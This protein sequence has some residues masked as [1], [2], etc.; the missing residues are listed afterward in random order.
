M[1]RT[2][3]ASFRNYSNGSASTA[4]SKT[5]ID[6]MSPAGIATSEIE[7]CLILKKTAQSSNNSNNSNNSVWQLHKPDQ[8]QLNKIMTNGNA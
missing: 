5:L 3:R 2:N 6:Q 4:T 8:V 7:D 1:N